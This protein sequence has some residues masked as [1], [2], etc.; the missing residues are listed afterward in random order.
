MKT[1]QCVILT[2]LCAA[3]VNCG[4]DPTIGNEKRLAEL[5]STY[6]A[7]HGRLEAATAKDPLVASA[8]ADRGSVV[9]AIRSGLIEELAAKIATRYLDDVTVDLHD[10]KAKG[11]GEV[12]RK[13]FLGHVK[14]GSW[15]VNVEL[16]GM[17]GDLRAGTPR[18]VLRAPNM[19]DLQIPVD[20]LETTGD[21]TLD[22]SW[23]SSGLANVVCKDFTLNRGIRGRVLPQKHTLSGAMRLEN[24]GTSL[25]ATPI[26]PDRKIELRLDLTEASWA[27]VE[28]ALRSQNT[29]DTCGALMKPEQALRFL[30]A[31]AAKG[32]GVKLPRSIFRTVSLPARLRQEVTVNRR[33]LS[34]AVT[35]E[36]LRIDG[37]TLWSSASVHIQT[38]AAPNAQA[39]GSF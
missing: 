20:V 30:K 23:D 7:L 6:D 28:Q 38:A 16:G 33:V 5:R 21:A 9:V 10:V 2:A 15:N 19:I 13:T 39:G 12:R 27:A 35:G 8:F 22:F 11:G 34:L 24:T 4:P 31:L 14:V 37:A 25:T 32:V 18:V 1:F 26:F 29:A 3:L 17:I 36:S